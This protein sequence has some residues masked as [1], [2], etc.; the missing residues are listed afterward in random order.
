MV[1]ITINPILAIGL[2]IL[3]GLIGGLLIK[4]AKLPTITG[5]IITGIILSPSLWLLLNLSPLIPPELV[6]GS[7]GLALITDFGLGII[8]FTVGGGLKLRELAGLGKV[9]PLL[10]VFE[11]GGAIL[12]TTLVLLLFSPFLIEL[13]SMNHYLAFAILIGTMSCA[14]APAATVAI[15]HEYRAGGPMTS[16]LLAIVAIDD[17]FALIAFA[18]GNAIASSLTGATI[19]MVTMIMHAVLAV[20]V[21][22]GVG[23][24]LGFLMI[25]FERFFGEKLLVWTLGVITFIVGL[26]I[27]INEIF[28]VSLSYILCCMMMGLVVAN[29]GGR[30]IEA[31]YAIEE[32]VFVLF[33]VYA[34]MSFEIEALAIAGAIGAL[35]VIGRWTGKYLGTRAA[36]RLAKAPEVIRRYL[37]FALLPKAGVTIGLAL[38]AS[39]SFPSIGVVLLNGVLASTIINELIAPPLTRYALFKAGEAYAKTV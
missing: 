37:G 34:G 30:S 38:L 13:P 27:Y 17:A 6:H 20:A 7:W 22:L 11:A 3:L 26:F 35:I 19:S 12:I 29:R 18:I 16:A 5:Y 33:F 2:I 28:G 23:A 4:K 25:S 8:G 9:I 1:M 21:S 14:T 10:L 24:L 32:L 39:K 36:G 15:V 31:T